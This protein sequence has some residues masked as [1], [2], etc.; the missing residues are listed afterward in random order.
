MSVDVLR[1]DTSDVY[2]P[3]MEIHIVRSRPKRQTRQLLYRHRPQSPMIGTKQQPRCRSVPLSMNHQSRDVSSV[4]AAIQHPRRPQTAVSAVTD[5]QRPASSCERLDSVEHEPTRK[6]QLSSHLPLKKNR[7]PPWQK[8]L[9]AQPVP[10]GV[11]PGYV[12]SKSKSK[13][14]MYIKAQQ[15][16]ESQHADDNEKK[17]DPER[18]GLIAQLQEQIDDLTVSLEEERLN[19]RETRRL[20]AEEIKQK[21]DELTNQNVDDIRMLRYEHG[22]EVDALS[23]KHAQELGLQKEEAE[24]TLKKLRGEHE[25]LQAAFESYKSQLQQ[26]LEEQW[27]KQDEEQKQK[28]SDDLREAILQ[29]KCKLRGEYDVEKTEMKSEWQKEVQ[30]LKRT[31]KKEMDLMIRRFS[32]A[33]ADL[34]RLEAMEKTEEERQKKMADMKE[35]YDDMFGRL[36]KV[37]GELAQTKIRLAC[38]E[39]EFDEHVQRIDE[40]YRGQVDNLRSQNAEL[41][42]LYVKKCGQLFEEQ[43]ISDHSCCVQLKT[44]KDVM[45]VVINTRNQSN[46]SV[47]GTNEDSNSPLPKDRPVSAPATSSELRLARQTAGQLDDVINER[48]AKLR[49]HIPRPSYIGKEGDGDSLPQGT[50]GSVSQ[51]THRT[52][53]EMENLLFGAL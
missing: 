44:A 48:N 14:A 16:F 18:D 24:A 3:P 23:V 40:K 50:S 10:W 49:A 13:I 2:K 12:L 52:Q 5:V 36:A 25:Y 15:F 43:V 20:A 35:E 33:A 30:G 46:I 11:G 31:H 47:A 42:R 53:E 19:H 41:R 51:T 22:Q 38:F 28:T 45:K 4:R 32:S 27:L 8:N 26:E 7:L 9:E 1:H 37:T 29:T 17:E 34:A 6:H 21:M 39:R